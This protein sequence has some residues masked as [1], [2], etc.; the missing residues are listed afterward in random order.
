M[1]DKGWFIVVGFITGL[2]VSCVELGVN[3]WVS[4]IIFAVAMGI[5]TSKRL[6]KS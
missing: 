2:Y 5:I 6:R 4:G 1:S 3:K